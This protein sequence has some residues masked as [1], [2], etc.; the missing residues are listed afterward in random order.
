MYKN[1][2]GSFKLCLNHFQHLVFQ[3]LL[4]KICS[5][6]DW[7]QQ[8]FRGHLGWPFVIPNYSTQPETAP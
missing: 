4:G 7:D 3:M 5:L 6:A 1:M 8:D 2:P